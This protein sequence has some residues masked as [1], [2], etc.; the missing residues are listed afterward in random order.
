MA[1]NITA[2]HITAFLIVVCA[3]WNFT[4]DTFTTKESKVQETTVI[5]TSG[6]KQDTS[7]TAVTTTDAKQEKSETVVITENHAKQND[8]DETKPAPDT[9]TVTEEKFETKTP[10]TQNTVLSTTQ[11]CSSDY[12]GGINRFGV[13][14]GTNVIKCNCEM[15]KSNGIVYNTSKKIVQVF[16]HEPVRQETECKKTC[17]T[18]C[19]KFFADFK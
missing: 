4:V 8:A 18:V 12:S 10:A 19:Q 2:I 5:T 15:K 7:K 17:D 16:H 14:G 1:R 9:V 6:V 13:Y 11:N 3:F